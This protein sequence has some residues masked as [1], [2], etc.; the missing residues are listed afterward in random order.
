MLSSTQQFIDTLE[1]KGIKYEINEPTQS[2]K[3]V[4]TV[5]Y[6]GDSMPTIRCLF[7]FDEDCE[8]VAIRVFDI[9]KVPKEK[10][11]AIF[12]TVNALNSKF[13]FV[14][15]CVHTEDSTVQA[16]MDASFRP[17]EMLTMAVAT[18]IDALAV[19]VSFAFL[20]VNI[21]AAVCFIGCITFAFGVA[22][23]KIGNVFGTRYKSRAEL[24]GG[25]ILILMGVKILIEHLMG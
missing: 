21:V 25:C 6:S 5:T 10:T 15:F 23:V 13:R 14:K 18:S 1:A 4:M 3:D 19:G 12:L 20:Q 22:G 16:E 9:L 2:G 24:A 8:S 7:F 11:A 17:K